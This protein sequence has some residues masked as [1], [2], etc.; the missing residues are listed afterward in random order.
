MT[1]KGY[2]ILKLALTYVCVFLNLK[3]MIENPEKNFDSGELPPIR[4]EF[5]S[6]NIKQSVLNLNKVI[7]DLSV[8]AFD[9]INFHRTQQIYSLL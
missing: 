8:V 5:N 4:P 2:I 1:N 3:S 7:L 6:N 9:Y